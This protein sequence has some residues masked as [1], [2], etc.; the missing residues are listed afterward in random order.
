MS[1]R[2]GK[3][4]LD[5][6][7]SRRDVFFFLV[8]TLVGLDT[9]G[10]VASRGGEGFVWLIFLAIFFFVPY[11]L[12]TAELGSAFPQEGGSYVWTKHALG[13]P[14][15]AVNAIF[16]WLSNP[17]WLGGALT[18]TAMTTWNT[19][20]FPLG[21]VAKYVFGLALIWACILSAVVSFKIG[22]W[23]AV[24]GACARVTLLVFFTF[25]VS[26]YAAKH[27]VHG[28]RLPQFAPTADG[29]FAVVPLLF[30]NF[31]GFELPSAA[32]DEM[33]DPQ[34][35][36]PFA[37]MRSA[38]ASVL[39]YG[40]PVL[41]ILLVLPTE[42]IT[43]LKGFI[44]A[45]Q[46]VFTVYGG[47]VET[48]ADGSQVV[49]LEGAG[50][51]L[52]SLAALGFIGA[53]ATSGTTWIMGADRSQAVACLDGAGPRFLGS[54]GG[55]WGTPVAVNIASGVVATVVMLAAF[56]VA[57]ASAEK[58]FVAS[59]NLGIS[60]TTISYLSI[61]PALYLLRRRCPDTKRPYRVPGGDRTA[62]LVTLLTFGWA[63][64]ATVCLVWPGF[65]KRGN[66]DAAL[67]AGFVVLDAHGAVVSSQRFLFELTQL[68]PLALFAALGVLFL[69]L[70]RRHAVEQPAKIAAPRPSRPPSL[71]PASDAV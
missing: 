67:P 60:T 36:V 49:V 71:R 34:R 2:Q 64:L 16:Y 61:F 70:G 51:T 69:V 50:K 6:S 12:L 66:A 46:T 9:L 30:F 58:F 24:F 44:D 25:S 56:A 3:P 32:G 38:I 42:R 11:A 41:A 48:I 54:F 40:V 19:F 57:G 63:L 52:G 1:A 43:G 17:I 55:R 65:G 26:L 45:M 4:A 27:G 8:C 20:F 31:V 39:C 35:D 14:I 10:S 23:I 68:V 37:V 62:L 53:L 15:A 21:A 18:I 5:K 29:F 13:K 7:L 33:V 28:I 47:H 59:L 22:K